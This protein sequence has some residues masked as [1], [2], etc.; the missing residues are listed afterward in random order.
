MDKIEGAKPDGT[1]NYKRIPVTVQVKNGYKISAITYAGTGAGRARFKCKCA[2]E[3]QVSQDYFQHLET[4]AKKFKFPT[5]YMAYLKE[6]AGQL[7][8][9]RGPLSLRNPHQ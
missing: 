9:G 4:G 6:K 7:A 2:E 3:Q 8:C 5:D 1:G